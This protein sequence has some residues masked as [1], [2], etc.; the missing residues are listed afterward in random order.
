MAKQI[1]REEGLLVS[2]RAHPPIPIC[3]VAVPAQHL[4]THRL[5]TPVFPSITGRD[6]VRCG[7]GRRRQS[8][9][10]G[11]EQGQAHRRKQ[12]ASSIRNPSLYCHHANAWC[13]EMVVVLRLWLQAI[14]A[15][16]GERYL[17]SFMY[18]SLKEEAESM[19]FEP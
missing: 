13:D 12:P 1:A 17:S 3:S 18:E 8:R 19:A 7:R 9:Q 16:F 6:I 5:R 4:L 2:E 10:E 11:R 14:F 15:S